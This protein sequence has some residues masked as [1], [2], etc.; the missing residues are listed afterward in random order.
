[1]P[2]NVSI[3]FLFGTVAKGMCP[4]LFLFLLCARGLCPYIFLFGTVYQWALSLYTYFLFLLCV[5]V[6]CSHIFLFGTVC[7]YFFIW[8]CMPGDCVPIF[9]YLALF[10]FGT[11]CQGTV[12]L[13]F[14][15]LTL[16]ARGLSP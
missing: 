12:S 6:L 1:M 2:G 8:H 14:F 16:C 13:Y 5:R 10:F 11:V 9:F 7:L 15:N 4:Y 3:Y